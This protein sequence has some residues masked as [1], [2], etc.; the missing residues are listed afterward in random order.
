MNAEENAIPLPTCGR[1]VN[2]VTYNGELRAAIVMKTPP[3]TTI[4]TG[5][6][7]VDLTV[8]EFDGPVVQLCVGYNDSN[9]PGTWHW[10]PYQLG[11]AKFGIAKP[12]A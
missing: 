4:G 7:L 10:M 2:Y 8:F 3:P 11:Q 12:G 6:Y 1:I 5:A 9:L